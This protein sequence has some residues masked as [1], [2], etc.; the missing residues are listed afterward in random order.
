MKTQSKQK[1]R[2][3]IDIGKVIMS[4]VVGGKADTSFLTGGIERAMQTPPSPDAFETV[5]VLSGI[6]SNQVWLVSKAGLNVQKKSRL[7]LRYHQF[8]QQTGVSENRLRFCFK[9]HQKADHCRELGITHFIDD[10]MDVLSHLRDSVPHLY[11]FG[12][13]PRRKYIPKWVTHVLNWNEVL[14]AILKD[15]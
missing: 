10:R 15:V 9:R 7:W 6:F 13:Q 8:Y 12:E 2:L 11:L 5:R 4:P 14:T 1:N 3:G